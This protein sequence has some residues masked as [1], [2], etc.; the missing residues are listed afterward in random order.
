MTATDPERTFVILLSYLVFSARSDIVNT[1]RLNRWLSLGANI[2]VVIG[3]LLVAYQIRQEANLAKLQL[4]SDHTDARR[5]WAQAMMGDDPMAV[6]AKSIERPEELTLA[7]L[8]I[9]DHYY[10]SA[11]NELRRL[12]LLDEA[13]LDTGVYIEGFHNFYFGSNFAKSW[14]EAYGLGREMDPVREKISA[15]RPDWIVNFFGRVVENIDADSAQ[16]IP[17][18]DDSE[19]E[20]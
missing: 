14:V 19:G 5:E 9:M 20:E 15:V 18:E 6:V 4:F 13:G 8:Q 12:E 16:S 1:K 17:R 3:L 10:I 2:G 11:L 7:E